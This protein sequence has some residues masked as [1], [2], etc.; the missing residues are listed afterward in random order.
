MARTRQRIPELS[1][2]EFTGHSS[3]ARY[4]KELRALCRDLSDEVNYAAEE[5]YAVLSRQKGHPLLAGIDVRMR[6]RRVSRRLARVSDLQAGAV[7]EAVKFYAEFRAQ[8][9][10]ALN[11]P[12]KQVRVQFDFSDDQGG[13]AR[14]IG[15]RRSA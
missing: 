12:K 9:A 13:D 2:I 8:F 10:E 15:D 5:L 4:A 14:V 7:I 1:G 3:V 11:P 6:A